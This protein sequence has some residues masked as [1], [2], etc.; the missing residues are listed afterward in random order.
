MARVN[1][2]ANTELELVVGEGGQMDTAGGDT[3]LRYILT[4]VVRTA[5]VCTIVKCSEC[6]VALTLTRYTLEE[7]GEVLV[8]AT[9][10]QAAN[11]IAGGDGYSGHNLSYLTSNIT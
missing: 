10:G 1:I 4:H 6:H 5:G 9:G 8:N 7:G 2:T 3:V 11:A